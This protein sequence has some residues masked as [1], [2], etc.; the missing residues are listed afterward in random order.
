MYR[1]I[2]VD[3]TKVSRLKY[4]QMDISKTDPEHCI[5][6]YTYIKYQQTKIKFQ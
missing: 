1:S 3:R 2:G 4:S 5:S 6:I